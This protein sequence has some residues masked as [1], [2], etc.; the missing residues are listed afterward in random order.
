MTAVCIIQFQRGQQSLRY[1]ACINLMVHS[2]SWHI[3]VFVVVGT[4]I[5]MANDVRLH[6]GKSPIKFINPT[7]RSLYLSML[8]SNANP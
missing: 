5:T 1:L 6:A 7:V 2:S 4:I 3:R 8:V